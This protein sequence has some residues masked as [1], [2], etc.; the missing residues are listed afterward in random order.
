MSHQVAFKSLSREYEFIEANNFFLFTLFLYLVSA[1]ESNLV[2]DIS[3]RLRILESSS[4]RKFIQ[5]IGS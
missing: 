4:F 1:Y 5:E 3:S 2:R